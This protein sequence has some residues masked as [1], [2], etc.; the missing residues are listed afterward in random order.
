MDN[1]EKS[2][3]FKDSIA[4]KPFHY[5]WANELWGKHEQMVWLEKEVKL[6][7]DLTA[8]KSGKISDEEKAFVTEIF[9]TFTQSDVNVGHNYHHNIIPHFRNNEVVKMLGGFANRE[10][11]H[12]NAYALL[13]DTLGFPEEFYTEFTRVVELAEKNDFMMECDPSTV[14]GLA[15]TLAKSIFNEGVSLFASFAMLLNFRRYGKMLGM[16]KMVEWSIKDETVHCEG[17]TKLFNAIVAEFP[18]IV[19]DDFKKKIYDMARKVVELEDIFSDI[20]YKNH[21]IEGLTKEEVNQYVRYITDRRLLQMGLKENFGVSENPIPW[22]DW[23]INAKQH[24]N[25]F[26]QRVTDYEAGGLEGSANYDEMQTFDIVTKTGCPYC[27][28]AK[29]AII[30]AG[31]DY[32]EIVMDDDKVRNEFYDTHG[33][34]GSERSVPKIFNKGGLFAK[35]YSDLVT[36]I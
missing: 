2:W 1:R 21:K 33:F 31:H 17:I 30:N 19:T 6:Q 5:P 18:E 23:I 36:K 9:K 14:E 29:E 10:G 12:Q 13:N 26:E 27:V 35:G 32:S 15:L 22:L 16:C 4:Y 24:T 7:E 25:F 3:L 11:T 34:E 8:W 28:K 20:A